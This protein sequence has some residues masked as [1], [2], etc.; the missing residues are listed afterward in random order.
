MQ[1]RGSG[2]GTSAGVAPEVNL[3]ITQTRKHA[4]DKP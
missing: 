4:S 3:R 1:V 2:S